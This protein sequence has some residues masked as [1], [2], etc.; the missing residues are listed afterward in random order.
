MIICNDISS[1]ITC[2]YRHSD[3]T[4]PHCTRTHLWTWKLG[5]RGT[6]CLHAILRYL[7]VVWDGL[8]QHCTIIFG[9]ILKIP[10]FTGVNVMDVWMF[11]FILI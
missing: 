6:E 4:G 11:D 3:A 2:F 1:F 5:D 8:N 10:I 9:P 7:G